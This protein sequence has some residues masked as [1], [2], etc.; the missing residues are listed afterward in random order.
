M[1]ELGQIEKH[2]SGGLCP[3]PEQ[4]IFRRWSALHRKWSEVWAINEKMIELHE[5]VSDLM[6]QGRHRDILGV[7]SSV[8]KTSAPAMT[9]LQLPLQATKALII[10]ITVDSMEAV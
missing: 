8:F 5:P 1:A 10:A 4:R 3:V 9:Q 2:F 6:I 7:A